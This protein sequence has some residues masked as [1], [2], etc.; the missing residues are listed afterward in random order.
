[1]KYV[2]I[3]IVI[4]ALIV[5]GYWAGTQDTEEVSTTQTPT[6]SVGATAT[7]TAMPTAVPSSNTVIGNRPGNRAPDFQLKSSDGKTVALRDYLGKQAVTL[8][9]SM[10]SKLTL[11][12]SGQ[13]FTLMDPDDVVHR[14]YNVGTMPYTITI[15]ANGT[16]R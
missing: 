7:F 15:D 11:Q 12:T 5:A 14:L 10:S 4:L 9:F 13:E 2:I 8:V 1:M 6:V 3:A 16:I